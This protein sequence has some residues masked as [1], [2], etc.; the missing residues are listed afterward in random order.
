[1]VGG[2]GGGAGAGRPV[3]AQAGLGEE[4]VDGRLEIRDGLVAGDAH[5]WRALPAITPSGAHGRMRRWLIA[6]MAYS[7]RD[8]RRGSA[9][10]GLRD[11]PRRVVRDE[12]RRRAAAV[13]VDP[14]EGGQC[15]GCSGGPS[16]QAS[17]IVISLPGMA[18]L[19]RDRTPSS[20]A[21]VSPSRS[22]RAWASPIWAAWRQ[23][24][25]SSSCVA[26][27]GLEEL[28]GELALRRARTT[29]DHANG[30]AADVRDR[31]VI[32]RPARRPQGVD[33]GG[34]DRHERRVPARHPPRGPQRRDLL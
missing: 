18:W 34:L 10:H 21:L 16:S 11:G 15:S 1:M 8:L 20:N 6:G 29:A 31:L 13:E 26:G 25:I 28:L 30:T 24:A 4:R 22:R 3:R 23:R 9:G 2:H 32:L 5:G 14:G 12:P 19:G 33:P 27:R 17:T 7:P